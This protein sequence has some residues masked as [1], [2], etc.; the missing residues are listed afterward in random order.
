MHYLVYE[1]DPFVRADICEALWS[2]SAAE[3]VIECESLAALRKNLLDAN[4]MSELTVV[5][6]TSTENRKEDAEFL[7][8]MSSVGRLVII[9]EERF[10]GTDAT[11]DAVYLSKPFSAH[12]L[13]AATLGGQSDQP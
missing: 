11:R 3:T 9:G 1:P 13:I 12:G 7:M 6:A 4:Q 8:Q 2:E 5:F 10:E